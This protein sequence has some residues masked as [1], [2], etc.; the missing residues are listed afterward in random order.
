[1]R[2]INI[3]LIGAGTVGGGVVKL[4]ARKSGAFDELLGLSLRLA[5]IADPATARFA[6]LPVGDACCS[7]S[8]DDVLRRRRDRHR[9]RADR[10]HDHGEGRHPRSAPARAST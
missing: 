9:R 2:T 4:L 8:A 6:E 5:R 3:G 10:R 7:A 1:M